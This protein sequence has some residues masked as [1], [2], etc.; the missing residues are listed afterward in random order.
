MDSSVV[1]K[2]TSFGPHEGRYPMHSRLNT[3]MKQDVSGAI[4]VKQ[5]NPG[6]PAHRQITKPQPT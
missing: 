2:D 5:L 1:H 3:E 4:D 6:G